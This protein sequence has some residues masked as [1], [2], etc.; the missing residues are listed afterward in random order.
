MSICLLCVHLAKDSVLNLIFYL[1][2]AC[3]SGSRQNSAGL[4]LLLFDLEFLVM[5]LPVI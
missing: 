4:R 1:S 3:F 2:Q 5:V